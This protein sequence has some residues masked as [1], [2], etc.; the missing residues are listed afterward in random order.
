M[1]ICNLYNSFY[2]SKHVRLIIRNLQVE[3]EESVHGYGVFVEFLSQYTPETPDF[4]FSVFQIANGTEIVDQAPFVAVRDMDRYF[5]V[6]AHAEAILTERSLLLTA[7]DIGE[8]AKYIW[9]DPA[10]KEIGQGLEIEIDLP[11]T[12]G[13][14]KLE[15][16]ADKDA[17]KDYD[18]VQVTSPLGYIVSLAPN[19]ANV[20]VTVAYFLSESVKDATLRIFNS[21]GNIVWE[22]KLDITGTEVKV[23]LDKL[24]NGTYSVV[25]LTNGG[26]VTDSKILIK[27]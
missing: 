13:L 10:G 18:Y 24:I 19:P 15:V 11:K 23:P 22:Q 17:Y 21:S 8:H 26:N 12:S 14:Y 7:D 3:N 25:L 16:I 27:Q 5:A 1:I 20:Y 2:N 4:D 9:Y 6:Q